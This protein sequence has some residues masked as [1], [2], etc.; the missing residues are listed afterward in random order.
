MEDGGRG[1][2]GMAYERKKGFNL[3]EE[4]NTRI[5]SSLKIMS[6]LF[7]IAVADIAKQIIRRLKVKFKAPNIIFLNFW[8]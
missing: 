2:P 3:N 4:E 5:V 6:K 1:K 8:A 7:F